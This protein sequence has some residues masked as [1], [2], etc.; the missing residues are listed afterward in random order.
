MHKIIVY[1]DISAEGI[2]L[3]KIIKEAALEVSL[4]YGIPI[5]IETLIVPEMRREIISVSVDGSRLYLHPKL[6]NKNQ[7]VDVILGELSHYSLLPPTYA[8]VSQ[9]GVCAP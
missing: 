3:E 7:L 2:M 5:D 8:R 6:L 4:S 1:R 9:M